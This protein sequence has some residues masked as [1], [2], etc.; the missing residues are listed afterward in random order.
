MKNPIIRTLL[1]AHVSKAQLGGFAVANLIGLTIVLLGLQFYADVRPV[2][3]DEDSFIRK[4][5]LVVTK[6]LG[7][8][9]MVKSLLGGAEANA[10]SEKEI[11]DI[12]SQPWLRNAGRFTTANYRIYARMSFAGRG[13]GTYLFLESVPDEFIDVKNNDWG[14]DPERGE[15]PILLSRDY[16]SLYNFGFATSQGMPQ[17]SESM[18]GKVPLTLEAR[19]ADGNRMG[20][21]G[22]IAGFSNRLNTIIVPEEFMTWSNRQFAPDV[23]MQPSRLILEVKN[24]GDAAIEKYLRKNGY[25]VAGDKM[26]SNKAAYMLTVIMGIVVAVGLVISLLS[27]FILMLSIYL[28]LQKNARKLRDLLLLGFSPAEVAAP[29]QRLVVVV[30][31]TV[32]VLAVTLMLIARSFYLPQLE[33]FRLSG[34]GVWISAGVGLGVIAA[35]TAGNA[36]AIRRKVASLWHLEK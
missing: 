14:F 3:D 31:A 30:N 6:S 18:V 32:Y 2:F 36:I 13:L 11:A 16:L 7:N 1:K 34:E 15:V 26:N 8:A 5:Y 25:E 28:L 24:P 10:F 21:K 35:I 29:Y 20:F 9:S 12:E 27:F 17:L 22:K 19:G 4:D 23:E 33:M